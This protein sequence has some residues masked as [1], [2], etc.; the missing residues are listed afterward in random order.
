MLLK[1]YGH[2]SVY[3]NSMVYA[4]GGFGHKDL[5]HE[6]PVTLAACERMNVNAEK[7]WSHTNQMNEPRAFCSY[8]T[9]NSQYIYV[10]GGMQD[11]VV[12]DSI[13]K[14]DTIAD[15]WTTM[16]FKLPRPLAKL[17]SVLLHDNAILIAGG[18]SRDFEPSAETYELSLNTLEW[19]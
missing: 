2:A 10:F 19:T 3:L 6:P 18:M 16:Y 11:Y 1:R 17:G 5:P 7:K 12:L 13:E 8:V 4:I 9:F 15:T 14:Y